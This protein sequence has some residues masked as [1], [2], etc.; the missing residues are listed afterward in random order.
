MKVL[1]GLITLLVLGLTA[2]PR[3]HGRNTFT[4]RFILVGGEFLFMGWALG[5]QGMGLLD[6]QAL[7]ALQPLIILGLGWIGL[8]VGLQF[9]MPI[10]RRIPSGFFGVATFQ[11]LT[12][13]LLLYLGIYPLMSHFSD[14]TP[15]VI[16]AT[17]FLAAAGAD[18]SQHILGLVLREH[19]GSS[20]APLHLLRFCSEIDS[21]IPLL[22]LA[23]LPGL[24]PDMGG[25]HQGAPG[26]L[27]GLAGVGSAILLGIFLGI[28][29]NLITH[30]VKTPSHH[31]LL[32]I[33]FLAFS[34]GVAR[35]LALP[36]LFVNFVAGI[37]SVNFFGHRS[38][39]WRL[40]AASEQPFYFIFLV[41]VGASWQGGDWRALALAPLFLGL[42][43]MARLLSVGT[44]GAVILR[45]KRLNLHDGLLLSGQGSVAV[46][47]V[48]SLQLMN[49][50][51]LFDNISTIILGSF[52][53]SSLI[54]PGL[55]NRGLIQGVP[56]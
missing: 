37:T 45:K 56:K 15:L 1:L 48:A 38:D 29:L 31:L 30:N 19:K 22:A 32:V 3:L 35:A 9:E 2:G 55:A 16:A 43:I 25:I 11:G 40:A 18:S 8:H 7:I 49:H 17:F 44:A 5:S 51:P 54:C 47:L 21:L 53:L 4:R 33:G 6:N 14:D 41:L 42:R 12:V 10:L 39:T 50:N 24:L 36:P 34:G 27:S 13:L 46:A 26:W 20:H 52:L 28:L 23:V